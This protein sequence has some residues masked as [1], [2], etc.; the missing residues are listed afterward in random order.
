M[1]RHFTS[2]NGGSYTPEELA[3]LDRDVVFVVVS[4]PAVLYS[5]ALSGPS[6]FSKTPSFFYLSENADASTS[7][8]VGVGLRFKRERSFLNGEHFNP[9]RIKINKKKLGRGEDLL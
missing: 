4:E 2:S 8:G 3:T 9:S 1:F 5:V 7:G 6:I